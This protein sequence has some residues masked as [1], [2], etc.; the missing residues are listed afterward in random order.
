MKGKQMSKQIGAVK[1]RNCYV[2][3]TRFYGG[4]K[5]GRCVQLT[6]RDGE[7]FI[8]LTESQV[9]ELRE[10]LEHAVADVGGES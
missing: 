5:D 10:I 9:R 4:D 1:A 6:P 8:Q 2:L 7:Q 3:V